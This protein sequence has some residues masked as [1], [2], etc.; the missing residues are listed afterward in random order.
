[1][2]ADSVTPFY[3]GPSD[4]RLFG[5]YYTPAADLQTESGVVMCN[6]WGQEYI[7]AHRALSQWALRLAREGFPVLRFDYFGQGDSSGDDADGTLIQWQA[8]LRHAIQ[9]LKRRARLETVFLAGLRLGAT[10]AA[11][12]AS[13]RDDVEGVVLWEPIINGP[14][15]LTELCAWHQ[16]KMLSFLFELNSPP[17]NSTSPTELLGGGVSQTLLTELQSLDLQTL[18]RKPA[19]KI[20]V[21]EGA[22]HAPVQAWRDHLQTL[23]ARA[24]Y[25]HIES[26]KLWTEDPDKGLVPLPLL[27]AA[28][29]WLKREDA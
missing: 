19:P 11:L 9:E 18:R 5:V 24:D 20:L 3:F 2:T 28:V 4:K 22:V 7:R 23:G 6:P 12:V 26:Y 10:V 8:D 16:E 13:G 29:A 1:M 14:E 25:E 27:Q 21:L 15:Y 17:P